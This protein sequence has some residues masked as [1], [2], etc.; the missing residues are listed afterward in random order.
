MKI[1]IVN[2]F[3]T[4]EHRAELLFHAFQEK[5]HRV[6]VFA[7]DFCHIEKKG[8]PV[9]QDAAIHKKYV[10]TETVFTCTAVQDYI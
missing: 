7:S 8:I 1:V 4:Y 10:I 9:F 5:G 2:C 6:E 3:D